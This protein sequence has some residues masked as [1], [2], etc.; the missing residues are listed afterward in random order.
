VRYEQ[1]ADGE[2]AGRGY[3]TSLP[4]QMHADEKLR[5]NALQGMPGLGVISVLN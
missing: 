3:V 4:W 2:A 5:C 1:K